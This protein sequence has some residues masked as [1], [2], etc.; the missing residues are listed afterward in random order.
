MPCGPHLAHRLE[1]LRS[2]HPRPNFLLRGNN[3]DFLAVPN[4]HF[5]SPDDDRRW[6][7]NLKSALFFCAINF[8]AGYLLA[9]PD[10]HRFLA[11]A[12]C[13]LAHL[14]S[15]ACSAVFRRAHDTRAGQPECS[16]HQLERTGRAEHEPERSKRAKHEPKRAER[17]PEPAGRAPAD[18]F[19]P[20]DR[21]QY[22]GDRLVL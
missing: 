22:G 2:M 6:V 5:P 15:S 14:V 4:N 3:P 10:V 7:A 1:L 16:K 9:Q 12:K 21:W 20:F 13:R 18:D 11:A 8:A 19:A 17:E